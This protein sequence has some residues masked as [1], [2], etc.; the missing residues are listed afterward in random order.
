M[1]NR[2]RAENVIFAPLF[3]MMIFISLNKVRAIMVGVVFPLDGI[4]HIPFGRIMAIIIILS[5]FM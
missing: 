5:Q 2:N 4:S 3:L 1:I